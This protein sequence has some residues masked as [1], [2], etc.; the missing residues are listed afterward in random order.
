MNTKRTYIHTY[1]HTYSKSIILLLLTTVLG[2]S[3]NGDKDLGQGDLSE[4]DNLEVLVK[5]VGVGQA[6]IPK[7][8]AVQIAEEWLEVVHASGTDVRW[9]TASK[10]T[11]AYPIKTPGIDGISYY[12]CKVMTGEQDTGYVLVN[13]NKTDMRIPEFTDKG[14]TSTEEYRSELGR[15]DFDVYRFDWFSHAAAERDDEIDGDRTLWTRILSQTGYY[16]Y[17]QVNA[18]LEVIDLKG[19]MPYYDIEAIA[20]YNDCD[21]VQEI[22][23]RSLYP[24][25]SGADVSG[26]LTN[27]TTLWTQPSVDIYWVSYRDDPAYIG[28]GPAAWAIVYEYWQQ[29]RGKNNLFNGVNVASMNEEDTVVKERMIELAQ[30]CR[31]E[32]SH[33]EWELW[34]L[35]W[36][37]Y[38][39]MGIWQ[40]RFCGYP[41][42]TVYKENGSENSKF[43]QIVDDIRNDNPVILLIDPDGASLPTHYVVIERAYKQY[44]SGHIEWIWYYAN[45][46]NRSH[47]Y[48]V[49]YDYGTNQYPVYTATSAYRI[50]VQ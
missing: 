3:L 48:I 14:I 30:L 50:H 42:S 10:V 31:T 24:N 9:T 6:W 27:S 2:C 16:G 45:W 40:A 13:V 34:G 46:G 28:C 17:E 43:L 22:L 39:D 44:Q 5:R 18:Y 15:N 25:P 20:K 1:I 29:F 47:E 41:A 49:T 36:P 11:A 21:Q 12:E 19:C 33:R 32:Y 35:T 26:S 37:W 4:E 8:T 7:E 38:M 23:P